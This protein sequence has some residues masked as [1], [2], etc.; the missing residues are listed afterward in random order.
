MTAL[1]L[2]DRIRGRARTGR[3]TPRPVVFAATLVLAAITGLPLGSVAQLMPQADDPA[4]R[5]LGL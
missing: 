4:D 1:P 3:R 2:F 5:F